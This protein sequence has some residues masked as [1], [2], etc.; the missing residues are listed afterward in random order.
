MTHGSEFFESLRKEVTQIAGIKRVSVTA[1]DDGFPKIGVVFSDDDAFDKVKSMY[2]ERHGVVAAN[3]HVR[4]AQEQ[5][6]DEISRRV[7][8]RDI[9]DYFVGSEHIEKAAEKSHEAWLSG[10][11]ATLDDPLDPF[12]GYG[13]IRRKVRDLTELERGDFKLPPNSD[14]S[15]DVLHPLFQPYI[16]IDPAVRNKNVVPMAAACLAV[17]DFLLDDTARIEELDTLIEGMGR[18]PHQ[19]A[20]VN[21]VM[22]VA[23]TASDVT[24]GGRPWEGAPENY[25]LYS[26]LSPDVQELDAQTAA[27]PL[28][29]VRDQ[30]GPV[31]N[32][33]QLMTETLVREGGPKEDWWAIEF[34]LL[35]R[36][37][38]ADV[39]QTADMQRLLDRVTIA[40]KQN[41]LFGK[42]AT[43]R[44][45]PP[46]LETALKKGNIVSTK[47]GVLELSDSGKER[48][49]TLQK[50]S[51]LRSFNLIQY[52]DAYDD[53]KQEHL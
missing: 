20:I 7:S 32:A 41:N 17:G 51:N 46:T 19:Q 25:H 27:A 5:Y 38:R 44:R 2:H 53:L 33:I 9:L 4:G 45:L 34:T 22:H 12:S 49:K 8:G 28:S 26:R 21:M 14:E 36:I 15:K 11:Q 37:Y 10:K 16:Q 23:W 24:V 35:D 43:E 18:S 3:I 1:T 31:D 50:I 6:W 48:L 39:W 30:V 13:P 29:Y 52:I 42:R 47:N 40:V